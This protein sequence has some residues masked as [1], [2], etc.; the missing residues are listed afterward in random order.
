MNT[1]NNISDILTN[2]GFYKVTPT[3]ELLDKMGLSMR[4]FLKIVNNTGLQMTLEEATAFASWLDVP[5][6]ELANK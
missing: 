4:R 5:V 3:K 6:D 2:R 1:K